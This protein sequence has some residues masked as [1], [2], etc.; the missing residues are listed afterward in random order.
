MRR[1]A[2]ILVDAGFEVWLVG[3]N[4]T[5]SIPLNE[6]KFKQ[7]RFHCFFERGKLFY[8]EFNIRLLLFL[9]FNKA[10]VNGAVDLD[11]ILANT[12]AAIIRRQKLVFDSHEYFTEVPELSGRNMSKAIWNG[13]GKL[14]IPFSVKAYTVAPQLAKVLEKEYSKPFDCVMNVP[15]LVQTETISEKSE[16]I[17]LYQGALNKG[18]CLEQIIRAMKNLDAILW[19]AGEGDLS[20]PLRALVKQEGLEAKAVFLGFVEPTDLPEITSKAY[21]GYNVLEPDGLSYQ[22]SLANKFFDYMHAQVP[23]LGPT[24]IEYEQINNKYEV[25]LL[26]KHSEEAIFETVNKLLSDNGLYKR[27]Q[28]N[29]LKASQVYNLQ[30]ESNK[31]ISI[32]YSL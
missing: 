26:C 13:I 5:G 17:I 21:I 1:H 22:Y 11:T 31:L 29:C 9:L 23:Q 2:S 8:L 27:L 3:R 32:Y 16:K 30:L 4:K 20:L 7:V 28:N 18:R 25:A 15:L 24:F 10:Y 12:L 19:I 14:C 6:S